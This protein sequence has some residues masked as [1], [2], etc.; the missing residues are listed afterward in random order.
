MRSHSS[1]LP[2]ALSTRPLEPWVPLCR[3]GGD[4]EGDGFLPLPRRTLALAALL[5]LVS[6]LVLDTSQRPE[7][8][9]S[10]AGICVFVCLLF[11]CSKH[12]RTVGPQPSGPE[13]AAAPSLPASRNYDPSPLRGVADISPQASAR[14]PRDPHA[15]AFEG[16]R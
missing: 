7:Q 11:A 3:G 1:L 13:C 4:A 14:P 16:H 5:G 6:W 12:H 8:L 10:F 9:V 15:P 2:P